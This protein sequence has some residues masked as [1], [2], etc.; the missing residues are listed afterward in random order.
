[1]IGATP[2]WG[3]GVRPRRVRLEADGAAEH[4]PAIHLE[5]VADVGVEV[6]LRRAV[7]IEV[8]REQLTRAVDGLDDHG[9][10]AVGE[11]DGG[12]PV[13]PVGDP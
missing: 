10:G 3:G 4:L 8:P 7:G 6:G 5:E 13:V 11:E 12:A 2:E 9:G 1:M